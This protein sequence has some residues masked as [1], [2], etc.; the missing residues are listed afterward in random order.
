MECAFTALWSSINISPDIVVGRGVGTLSAAQA[1]GA[2]SLEEGLR[3]AMWCGECLDENDNS[4]LTKDLEARLAEATL[5]PL[6]LPMVGGSTTRT[7]DSGE[8]PDLVSWFGVKLST[9]EITGAEAALV[10]KNTDTEIVIGPATEIIEMIARIY[11]LGHKVDFTGLF[12]GE[13]RRRI[14]IPSYP[15]QRQSYW[16]NS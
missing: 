6:R 16:F 3:L 1:A 15:F 8:V 2:L 7:M 9:G 5:T 10:Q 14:S 13:M 12:A 11:E 4:D